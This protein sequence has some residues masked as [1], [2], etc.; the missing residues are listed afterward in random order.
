MSGSG[1]DPSRAGEKGFSQ[2]S[3]GAG[4]EGKFAQSRAGNK[5]HSGSVRIKAAPGIVAHIE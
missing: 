4:Q 3:E 2:R 1:S 5:G